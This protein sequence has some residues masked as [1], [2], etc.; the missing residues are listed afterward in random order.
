MKIIT[1]LFLTAFYTV[2][3]QNLVLSSGLGMSEAFRVSAKPGTFG[4]IAVMISG[5]SVVTSALCAAVNIYAVEAELSYAVR[6]AVYGIVL[7]AVYAVVAITARLVFKASDKF[8]G[9]LGIA[10]F[11]TLVFA[12]PHINNSAAYSFAGSIGSGLGAGVAFILAAAL[13]NKG[14]Q[15]IAENEEI[16]DA[17]KGTPAMFFYVALISLAFA[18]FTDTNLFG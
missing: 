8:L 3:V 9:T 2:F 18:G 1:D 10:A 6:A 4:R 11:N 16:P 7:A 12:I 17:F 15:L 13:I 5:F 14:S